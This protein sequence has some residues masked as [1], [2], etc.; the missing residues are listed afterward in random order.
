MKFSRNSSNFREPKKW[1]KQSEYIILLKNQAGEEFNTRAT[2]HYAWKAAEYI[3]FLE[4][5]IKKYHIEHDPFTG[6]L[7]N[8]KK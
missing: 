3:E 4:D 8:D 1:I 6:G 5:L 2:E 7:T